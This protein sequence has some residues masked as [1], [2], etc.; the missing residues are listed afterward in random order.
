VPP[1]P[2]DDEQ[3]AF[4]LALLRGEKTDP[5]FPPNPDQAAIK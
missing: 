3:I 5:A 4:A 2:E 1:D